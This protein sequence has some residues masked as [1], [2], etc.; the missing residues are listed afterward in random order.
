MLSKL[1][2]IENQCRRTDFL[3]DGIA[4]E[5]GENWN[6]SEKKVRQMFSSDLGL[7]STKMDIE[8]AQRIGQFQEG[9]EAWE[10]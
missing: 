6:E 4:D 9:G 2:Y 1:D 10:N 5:K 8:R 3:I 7:D